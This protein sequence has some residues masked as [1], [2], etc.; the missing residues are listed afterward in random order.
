M[1][2]VVLF[3]LTNI[4]VVLTINILIGDPDRDGDPAPHSTRAA[5]WA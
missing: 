5:S 4:A 2:R 3:V 1:K